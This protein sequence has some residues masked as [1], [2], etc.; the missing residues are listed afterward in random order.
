[1]GSGIGVGM[2][3]VA[4][5]KGVSVGVTSTTSVGVGGSSVGVSDLDPPPQAAN[6]IINPK[7]KPRYLILNV[8]V[9]KGKIQGYGYELARHDQV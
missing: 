4:V 6:S 8:I 1:M 5:G 7:S 2:G 3:G 9:N